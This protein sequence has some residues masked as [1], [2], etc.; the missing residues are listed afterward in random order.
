M[1]TLSMFDYTARQAVCWI[2]VIT[3]IGPRFTEATLLGC[4]RQFRVLMSWSK[5]KPRNH[6]EGQL[7]N[8]WDSVPSVHQVLYL[9][10]NCCV[11]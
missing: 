11:L 4:H 9:N 8:S 5:H 10:W 3:T 6:T 1:L 7:D 2:S